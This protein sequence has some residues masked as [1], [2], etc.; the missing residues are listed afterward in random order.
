MKNTRASFRLILLLTLCF[1]PLGVWLHFVTR[2]SLPLEH[3]PD[4]NLFSESDI[5][6]AKFK[7]CYFRWLAAIYDREPSVKISH[8]IAIR[9]FFCS[10]PEYTKIIALGLSHQPKA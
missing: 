2:S 7:A 6:Q 1:I 8:T 5:K 9:D 4:R 3:Q 10:H